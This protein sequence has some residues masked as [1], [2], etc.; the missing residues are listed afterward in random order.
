MIANI[1]PWYWFLVGAGIHLAGLIYYPPL[2]LL[3]IPVIIL[4][5]HQKLHAKQYKPFK[6]LSFWGVVIIIVLPV[7]GMLV[8]IQLLY[9]GGDMPDIK[10][11]TC[12]STRTDEHANLRTSLVSLMLF[13]IMVL[14]C[15]AA[16]LPGFAALNPRT[17]PMIFTIGAIAEIVLLLAWCILKWRSVK[18][19]P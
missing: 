8:A 19:R 13:I 11:G 18:L 6:M 5:Y 3:S 17:L 14:V 2:Y 4:G 15:A 1:A 10:D 12:K 9:K 7:V 16:M